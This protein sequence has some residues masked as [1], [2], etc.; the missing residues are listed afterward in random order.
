MSNYPESETPETK[1]Q[2]TQVK[3]V[4]SAETVSNTPPQL[5]K[6]ESSET[7]KK[8]SAYEPP[9][10]V[11]TSGQF[12]NTPYYSVSIKKLVILY[13]GT[14]GV[15]TIVWFYRHWLHQQ[16][17]HQDQTLPLLR[18]C[19]YIFFTHSLFS[20]M[21]KD[22]HNRDPKSLFPANLIATGFVA[23]TATRFFDKFFMY[24]A[25]YPYLAAFSLLMML[26]SLWPLV[27]AQRVANRLN[28]DRE[29]MLNKNFTPTNLIGLLLGGIL[30]AAAILGYFSAYTPFLDGYLQQALSF[31]QR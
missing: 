22:L 30:W 31:Y 28:Y 15:Y 16:R 13:L 1:A 7:E 20:K 2:D 21:A 17:Y 19:L 27:R 8:K 11:L 10:A 9:E 4:I 23:M 26:C 14:F 12:H 29:G 3:D 25:A 6:A 5:A 24:E 18:G